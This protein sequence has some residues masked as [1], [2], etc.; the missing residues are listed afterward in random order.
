MSLK[1]AA[2]KERCD[3]VTAQHAASVE[4]QTDVAEHLRA[5]FQKGKPEARKKP[6][7]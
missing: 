2:L 7:D 1:H 3:S 4:A 6:R 5:V